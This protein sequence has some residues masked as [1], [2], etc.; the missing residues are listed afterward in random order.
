MWFLPDDSHR[1]SGAE[2]TGALFPFG[3]FAKT[4]LNIGGN[5]GV[6]L[7]IGRLDDVDEPVT[8]V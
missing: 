4:P 6:E 8:V 2:K 3:V 5:A 1:L 7:A